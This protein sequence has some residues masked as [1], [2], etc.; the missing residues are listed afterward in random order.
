MCRGAGET[1]LRYRALFDW[2]VFTSPNAVQF[3]FSER[4]FPILTADIRG[5]GSQSSSLR[6]ARPRRRKLERASI[7]GLIFNRKSIR[8]RNWRKHFPRQEIPVSKRFL[9]PHGELGRIRRSPRI[10]YVQQGGLVE[11][12]ILYKT[13]PE[14]EDVSVCARARYLREGAHWITFTSSRA[15]WRIG[16]PWGLDFPPRRLTPA[17]EPSALDR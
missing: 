1:E 2:V 15:R 16:M 11:E 7:C 13:E 9:L 14:T 10:I 8:Q 5:F 4:L 17:E 3:F 6:S 12:W